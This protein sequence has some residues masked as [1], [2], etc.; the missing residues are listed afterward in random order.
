MFVFLSTHGPQIFQAISKRCCVERSSSVQ[1]LH[2]RSLSDQSRVILPTT[3]TTTWS[4]GPAAVYSPDT[5]DESDNHYSTINDIPALNPEWVSLFEQLSNSRGNVGKDQEERCHSLDAV[6][7]DKV[8][9]DNIYYNL[10][11]ATPPMSRY[12]ELKP[13]VDSECVYSDVKIIDSPSN[14]QPQPFSPPLP[15]PPPP[16]T[17]PKPRYQRQP[18]AINYTQAGYNAQAQAVDD[19]KEM[20]EAISSSARVTPSEA[21]GSFKHRLAEIISKDLAKLQP[22]LPSGAG[23]PTFSQ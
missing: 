12:N 19:M 6:H 8:Q 3:T 13:E 9:E 11:K 15:Q 16:S 4:S 23:S 1:S 10:K 17:P 5:E 2:R 14:P 18:P 20:E 7:L 21:P 22:A